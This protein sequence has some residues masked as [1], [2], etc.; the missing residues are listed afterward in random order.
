LPDHQIHFF[1]QKATSAVERMMTSPHIWTTGLEQSEPVVKGLDPAVGL[2]AHDISRALTAFQLL[3]LHLGH[4]K[5]V[6]KQEAQNSCS[7]TTEQPCSN[8]ISTILILFKVVK[9]I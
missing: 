8:Q 7:S 6:R 9:L 5:P 1:W 2:A 4:V 3:P